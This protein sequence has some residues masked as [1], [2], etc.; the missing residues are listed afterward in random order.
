[1]CGA[2]ACGDP[3]PGGR[4]NRSPAR[5]CWERVPFNPRVPSGTAP[6]GQQ[7]Q[8]PV[9]RP[10]GLV[11][12]INVD[13]GLTSW[14]TIV[15]PCGLDA[16]CPTHS[17]LL[18]MSGRP[19]WDGVIARFERLGSSDKDGVSPKHPLKQKQLEWGTRLGL[20]RLAGLVR[21]SCTRVPSG[22][23]TS[24]Q[25]P[26]AVLSDSST[27]QAQPRTDVLG[28]DYVALRALASSLHHAHV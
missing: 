6:L 28:Y 2:P 24:S 4:N 9:C 13:P 12:I 26:C 16:G 11:A 8:I 7:R 1:M 23:N 14:A 17:R 22:D 27:F 10:V 18:R 19:H 5:E 15:S 21:C 3:Q 25:P 20:F